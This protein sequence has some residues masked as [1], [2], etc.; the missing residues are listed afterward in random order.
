MNRGAFRPTLDHRDR[1]FLKTFHPHFGTTALPKFP[2]EFV[3]D[4][5]L[6]MPDQN[7]I[8]PE[9]PN[10]PPQPTG[11]TNFTTGDLAIDIDGKLHDP[12]VMESATHADASGGYDIRQSLLAA[13]RIGLISG[14]YNIKAYAPL[15]YFD[16]MRL[17]SF[18]GL[19]EKRSISVGTPWYPDWQN[20]INNGK[21]LMPSPASLSYGG[22]GWHNWKVGGW[23]LRNGSP[24]LR[25]KP[26]E[27]KEIGDSG[28]IEF[29]R[30][31]INQVMGLKY[32]IA[33][34]ATHITPDS[35]FKIDLST[36]DKYI[37]VL[38]GLLGLRY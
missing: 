15:D 35:V 19:P 36:M 10:T 31:T 2:D 25:A 32:T 24:V 21:V 37:S 29:D 22:L 28:W 20:A 23:R 1:D 30:P 8:N 7:A 27:G 34:T 16:A 38:R 12:A 6:W 17:A 33:F 9:F 14:F 11:C 4:A 13:K 18:S 26:W 3:T 5:G